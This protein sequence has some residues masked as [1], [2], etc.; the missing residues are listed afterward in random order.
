VNTQEPVLRQ[1]AQTSS[2]MHC[3]AGALLTHENQSYTV[4][5]SS[6]FQYSTLCLNYALSV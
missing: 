3:N 6:Y 2:E 4:P 1:D 5:F